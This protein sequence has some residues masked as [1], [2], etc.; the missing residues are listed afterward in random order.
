MKR[1]DNSK[2][3]KIVIVDLGPRSYDVRIGRDLLDQLGSIAVKIAGPGQVAVI[4]ESTVA[5]LYA[6]RAVDSLTAAGMDAWLVSFPAGEVNKTLPTASKLLDQLLSRTPAIDRM[7]LIVALGGGVTGDLGGF[8]AATALRGL[9]WIQCPTTLLSDVDASVGGKTGVDHS[10][11]KNLIG[12]FHQPSG[13]L[14][15]VEA[16]RT[17]PKAEL[18]NGLAECV[19]HAIIRD[20]KLLDFIEE[21]T[22]A[23]L[24]ETEDGKPA[25]DSDI[26][27][28][29]IARNVAIKSDVV[30]GDERESAGRADL[31]FGHTIGHAIE[32]FVGYEN[33]RHGEAVA[34]GIIAENQLAV[35]R[36]LLEPATAERVS[37]ALGRLGLPVQQPDLDCGQLWRIMQHDKKARGG[38]VRIVLAKKLGSVDIYDDITE[39]EVRRAIDC[40]S[41]Q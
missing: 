20:A 19:K 32:T 25:F 8:V 33:I 22:D 41:P 4:S 24:E 40:L 7:T 27:I 5:G 23:L 14:V 36:G 29:L 31:N 34:L 37:K 18:A 9:R 2:M 39:L 13:V 16:L 6:Q 10:A 12:A 1:K 30:A 35:N 38:K 11:G 28:D 17:L 15:D 3:Q 26:M 21:H